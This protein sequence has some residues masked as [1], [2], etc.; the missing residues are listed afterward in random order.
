MTLDRNRAFFDFAQN[1]KTV[2]VPSPIRLMLNEVE[3]RTD[4][5]AAPLNATMR[6]RARLP[7]DLLPERL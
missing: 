4:R 1:E 7:L 3:A 2:F 6:S 5:H